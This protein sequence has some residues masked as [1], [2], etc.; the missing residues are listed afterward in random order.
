MSQFIRPKNTKSCQSP[1][2]I[3]NFAFA[4][5]VS[6][7]TR[8]FILPSKNNFQS[9]NTNTKKNFNSH[10][11][12]H[13]SES[14]DL[15]SRD[16]QFQVFLSTSSFNHAKNKSFISHVYMKMICYYTINSDTVYTVWKSPPWPIS[17]FCI[18]E[19]PSNFP[20]SAIMAYISRNT[21]FGQKPSYLFVRLHILLTTAVTYFCNADSSQKRAAHIRP[22]INGKKKYIT[23]VH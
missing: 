8:P 23:S 15:K 9:T 1:I 21:D 16:N 11:Q 7:K 12:I 14:H 2:L 6:I 10:C 17:R 20:F 18:G 4:S 19:E 22:G 5:Q 3:R 13:V